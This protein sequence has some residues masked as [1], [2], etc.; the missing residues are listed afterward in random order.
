[1]R[2]V[3]RDT[4]ARP[5]SGKIDR[6][7]KPWRRLTGEVDPESS[8][9]HEIVDGIVFD[10]K[11]RPRCH[12]CT[13]ADPDRGLPNGAEVR[14]DI[15]RGLVEGDSY[16]AIVRRNEP[17]TSDWPEDRRP[18]YWSVRRHAINHLGADAANVRAIVERRA[19]EAGLQVVVGEGPLLTKAAVLE[20]VQRKGFQAIV[21]GAAVPTVRETVEATEALEEL[22]RAAGN[23]VTLEDLAKQAHAFSEVVRERLGSEAYAE[24]LEELANRLASAPLALEENGDG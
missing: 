24:V 18:S 5:P 7:T 9:D 4:A 11:G 6:R 21:S 19:M 3:A 20:V 13:A 12:I 17:R 8:G 1:V 22:D 10:Y 16:A 2:K 15:D 23:T 14:A